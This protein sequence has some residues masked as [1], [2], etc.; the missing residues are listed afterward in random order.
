[1][2][3]QRVFCT[4]CDW[5]TVREPRRGKEDVSTRPCPE[6]GAKMLAAEDYSHTATAEI[7]NKPRLAP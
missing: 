2:S 3:L 1:M 6:C 4:S 7:P 5:Q